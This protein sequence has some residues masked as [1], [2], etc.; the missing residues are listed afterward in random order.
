MNIVLR[1]LALITIVGSLVGAAAIAPAQQGWRVAH[2]KQLAAAQKHLLNARQHHDWVR[3]KGIEAK[4]AKI[5]W[6][7]NHHHGY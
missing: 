7:L 5:K 2:L 6:E 4:I 3:A 1:K